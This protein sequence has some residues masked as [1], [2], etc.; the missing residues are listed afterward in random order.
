M[1]VPPRTYIY[2]AYSHRASGEKTYLLRAQEILWLFL[3]LSFSL[4]CLKLALDLVRRHFK[5]TEKFIA[6][7]FLHAPLLT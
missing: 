4:L 1:N 3:L 7:K 2:H 5:I 6:M